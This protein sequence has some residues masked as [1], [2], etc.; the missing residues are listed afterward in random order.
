MPAKDDR[1]RTEIEV[2]V[3]FTCWVDWSADP[4]PI[5]YEV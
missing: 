5:P 2:E 4:L 3:I 1:L